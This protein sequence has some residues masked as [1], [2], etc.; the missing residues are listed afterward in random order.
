MAIGTTV[1]PLDGP[2]DLDFVFEL[3]I[4]HD[5]INPMAL[6]WTFYDFLKGHGTYGDKVSLKNRCVRITYAND[7]YMDVLP[8]CKDLQL[9][10]TCIKVPDRELANWTPSNPKGYVKWCLDYLALD[11][12]G[13]SAC[14]TTTASGR[15]AAASTRGAVD[16]ALA[17]CLLPQ[18]KTGAD[19]N[20]S[21]DPRWTVL[22]R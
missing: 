22:S 14:P 19:L 12:K 8:S 18:P 20:R 17:G 16:E 10:G 2:H 11:R 13:C 5:R 3:G 15:E 6:L 4:P 1:H 21:D 9:G 7:F